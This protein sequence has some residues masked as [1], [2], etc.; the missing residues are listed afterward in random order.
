MHKPSTS[1]LIRPQSAPSLKAQSRAGAIQTKLTSSG[2]LATPASKSKSRDPILPKL[3]ATGL[4]VSGS[5]SM[6]QAGKGKSSSRTSLAFKETKTISRAQSRGSLKGD[7]D[8]VEDAFT[9]R[10]QLARF[11]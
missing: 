1:K 5:M 9:F 11:R 7:E 2:K 3:S 8:G 4:K 10:D 6:G